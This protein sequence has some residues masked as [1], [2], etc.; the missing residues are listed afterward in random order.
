MKTVFALAALA[1]AA[2][3]VGP[4]YA[5]GK[6]AAGPKSQWQPSRRS[7]RSCRPRASRSSNQDRERLL[8][9]LRDR[10]GRQARQHGLQRP[11]AREARQ[12]RSRRE[13][14]G[15]G[16]PRRRGRGDPRLGPAG[17]G[18]PLGARAELRRLLAQRAGL[19]GLAR[20]GRLRRRRAGSGARRL[21]IRRW[22]LRPLL[23]VRA[24][25]APVFAYLGAIAR[26][27]EARFVG[28]NPAGGATIVALLIVIAATGAGCR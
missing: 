11:D 20:L 22:R 2:V 7:N 15:C 28:H 25:A 10:Q 8:R 1:V 9:G 5:A 13:L 3:A 18:V 19:G 26:G 17:S 12:R 24:R 21:G 16:D 4:A 23:S 27:S 14:I 6:C